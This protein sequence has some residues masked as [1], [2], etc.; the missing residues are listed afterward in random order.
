MREF[1]NDR[2]KKLQKT[3]QD[4]SLDS[5][6]VDDPI[7]LLYL[8]GLT[9]SLGNLFISQKDLFLLVDGRYFESCKKMCPF[10]VYLSPPYTLANLLESESCKSI[11]TL[12]FINETTTYKSFTDLQET[13]NGVNSKTQRAITVKP[14]NNIIKEQRQVKEPQELDL[15]SQAAALGSLGYDFVC[16]Q[17]KEG[18]S[19]T[20]LATELEIFW[21]RKGGHGLAF[22]SIIAFGP[23]SSMP[24]YR[25]CDTKLKKGDTVLIDIGVKYRHYHSDM[26]RVVFFGSPSEQM[27]AIY[28]VV[29]DAQKASLDLC[30]PGV[31]VGEL[32]HAARHLITERGYGDK[33]PHSLGHGVGLE[34]HEYPALRNT[35]P[36]QDLIL[37]AGMVITIEPGVYV[38][39]V[40]GVRIEDTIVITTAGH[41]NL[42][43][44]SKD[45][46]IV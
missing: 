5:L 19:E 15:L 43:N 37:E 8:T 17:L 20:E 25:A 31:T 4:I 10:P 41:D 3:L 30:R 27:R 12:G 29:K 42:T 39:G 21:K 16:T 23:N 6:L 2:I 38:P 32:D 9:L 35:P 13:I 24:H 7:N 46:V 34:I 40:G 14:V 36:Y 33:F 26:T 44:R 18:I 22:D 1:M 11:E 28:D 45:L